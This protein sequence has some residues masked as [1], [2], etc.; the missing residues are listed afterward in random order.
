MDHNDNLQNVATQGTEQIKEWTREASN[1]LT[2][3][4]LANG[5]G[6]FSIA[7]GATEILAPRP[8]GRF[9]GIRG[10]DQLTM[11]MGARE[12]A[13]GLGLL[14]QRRKAPWMWARFVGDLLDLYLLGAGL[15]SPGSHRTRA[16]FAITSVAKVTLLDLYVARELTR[17]KR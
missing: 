1:A 10:H 7:L 9:I 14:T 6:W 2:P 11:W 13:A 16:A 4:R 15:A 17:T 8:L 12:I 3:E 5:L